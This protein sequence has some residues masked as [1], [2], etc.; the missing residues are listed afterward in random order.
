MAV[1]RVEKRVLV[2]LAVGRGGV[3]VFGA[4]DLNGRARSQR[5]LFVLSRF[6]SCLAYFMLTIIH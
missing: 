3:V 4:H 6:E 1:V 2:V 5:D